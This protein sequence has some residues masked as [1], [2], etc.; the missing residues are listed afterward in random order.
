[1]LKHKLDVI[2]RERRRAGLSADSPEVATVSEESEES[3]QIVKEALDDMF[4]G[5]SCA[6]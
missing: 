2:E 4:G 3:E 5:T 6:V 1:M